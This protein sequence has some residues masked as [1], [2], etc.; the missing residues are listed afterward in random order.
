MAAIFAVF[1]TGIQSGIVGP[2][3]PLAVPLALAFIVLLLLVLLT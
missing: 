1:V 2:N 3:D